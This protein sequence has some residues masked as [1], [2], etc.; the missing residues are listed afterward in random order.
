MSAF[1]GAL[2]TLFRK[3]ETFT[4]YFVERVSAS[5]ESFGQAQRVGLLIFIIFVLL[6]VWYFVVLILRFSFKHRT[7]KLK[8][9][10]R[11]YQITLNRARGKRCNFIWDI[12]LFQK[13][14]ILDDPV[15]PKEVLDG[16][17][18]LPLQ[19]EQKQVASAP[20]EQPVPEETKVEDVIVVEPEPTPQPKPEPATET[21]VEE[22][23]EPVQ[24]TIVE[25]EEKVEPEPKQEPV[26]EIVEEE[27]VVVEVVNEPTQVMEEVKP[28]PEEK[29]EP[30]PEVKPEPKP[31]A[32]K[33]AKVDVK[34]TKRDL[35]E[36]M[37]ENTDLNK[38]KAN[39]FLKYFAEVITEVLKESD[40]VKLDS[41]GTF[42]V[43]DIEESTRYIPSKDEM[44]VLPAHKEVRYRAAKE[45]K[46]LL[47]KEQQE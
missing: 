7:R 34:R 9:V 20:K 31:K 11:E 45:L 47:N 32:K 24:E 23:V 17:V 35:I 43:L 37:V 1:F 40:S 6:F 46:D 42:L 28:E 44:R 25:N 27:P 12:L 29:T 33:E 39:K 2:S 5:Y 13:M 3:M 30:K 10:R 14:V 19:D 8:N 21:I 18:Y 36:Y 41:F 16:K 38:S 26:E 22:K 4:N 15:A